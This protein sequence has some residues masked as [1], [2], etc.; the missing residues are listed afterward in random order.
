MIEQ[1]LIKYLNNKLGVPVYMEH[2]SE[3][4]ASYVVLEKVGGGR[5]N[6]LKSATIALQSIASTL[7]QAAFLNEK[8]KKC[9][10]ELIELPRVSKSELNSDYNFTDSTT[11]TYR[12]QAVYDILYC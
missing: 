8:V 11:K 1:V 10:D 2:P 12:Y 5:R 6:Y 3:K 9:M 7:E 4:P